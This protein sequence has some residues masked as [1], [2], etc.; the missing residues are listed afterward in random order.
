MFSFLFGLYTI[1]LRITNDSVPAG[2]TT[3]ISL[4]VFLFGVLLIILGIM[5]EYMIDLNR[6]TKNR[7]K[8]LIQNK[9]NL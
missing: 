6:Q 2:Y 3:I 9:I 4:F 5:G 1:I 8:Y 7:P